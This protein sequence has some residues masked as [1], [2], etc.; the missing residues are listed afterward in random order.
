MKRYK[1]TASAEKDLIGIWNYTYDTWGEAQADSYLSKLE[2]GLVNLT[3][4]PR[5]HK[6]P[7]PSYPGVRS[8]HC[9]HHYIFF[10]NTEKP[11]ILAIL[12]E[13]MDLMLRLKKILLGD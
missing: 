10:L 2:V 4:S 1:L 9:E 11:I 8:V 12:H 5:T 3:K 6:S 7:L 13:K